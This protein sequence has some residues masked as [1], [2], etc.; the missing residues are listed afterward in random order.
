MP[1]ASQAALR[2]DPTQRFT[3][4]VVQITGPFGFIKVDSL[5]SVHMNQRSLTHADDWPSLRV[6]QQVTLSVVNHFK[7]P[8]A[9]LLKAH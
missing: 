4:V 6:G 5:G 2:S 1:N 7:G 8:H 3:G 9:V